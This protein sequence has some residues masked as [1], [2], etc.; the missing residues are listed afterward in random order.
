MNNQGGKGL[1]PCMRLKICNG[2]YAGVRLKTLAE[3]YGIAE[4]T[5]L[6]YMREYDKDYI[7]MIDFLIYIV[8]YLKENDYKSASDFLYRQKDDLIRGLVGR[9]RK[10]YNIPDFDANILKERGYL[11]EDELDF[12]GEEKSSGSSNKQYE[13][14]LESIL[15]DGLPPND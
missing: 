9:E 4:N 6:N 14:F 11:T 7:K 13:D 12:W 1:P 5:I 2:H 15:A 3:A 10:E 8:W